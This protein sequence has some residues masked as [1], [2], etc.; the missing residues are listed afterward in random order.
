MREAVDDRGLTA[1]VAQCSEEAAKVITAQLEGEADPAQAFD[2][3][4]NAN[5]AIWSAFIE[6]AGIEWLAFEGCPLCEIGRQDDG[7]PAEWINGSADGQ[8]ARARNLGLAPQ[9]Q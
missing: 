8:L 7:L 9:V 3:L 4:M 6:D 5:F 2:P 1:F